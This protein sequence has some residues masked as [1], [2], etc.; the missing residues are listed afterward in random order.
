MGTNFDR[1]NATGER[2]ASSISSPEAGRGEAIPD[3]RGLLR[4]AA[5]DLRGEAR[6]KVRPDQRERL[7]KLAAL[8]DGYADE[9]P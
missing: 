7:L 9:S 4:R 6:G 2:G 5:N 3:F 1:S 8:L